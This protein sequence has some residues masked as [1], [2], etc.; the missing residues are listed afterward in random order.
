MTGWKPDPSKISDATLAAVNVAIIGFILNIAIK[1]FDNFLIFFK[2]SVVISIGV[3]D[4]SDPKKEACVKYQIGQSIKKLKFI[5]TISYKNNYFKWLS[6]CGT[7]QIVQFCWTDWFVVEIDPTKSSNLKGS[8]K[9]NCW[10]CN[11][12]ELMGKDDLE[13]SV[14]LPFTFSITNA[15]IRKGY[16]TPRIQYSVKSRILK[17]LLFLFTYPIVSISSSK[18]EVILTKE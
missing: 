6:L 8:K 5:A 12:T 16:I 3:V 1:L 7:S 2:N 14:E 15:N 17:L 18:M 9:N 13:A 11:I 10:E 4:P